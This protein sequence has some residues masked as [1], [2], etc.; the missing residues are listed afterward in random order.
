MHQGTSL[1]RGRSYCCF[2]LNWI[3]LERKNYKEIFFTQLI[4][5][6]GLD[7]IKCHHNDQI[8]RRKSYATVR[9]LLECGEK[10]VPLS[11]FKRL[12]ATKYMEVLD[13][14]SIRTMKHA[15]EVIISDMNA[16][17]SVKLI[18]IQF[19]QR[20]KMLRQLNTFQ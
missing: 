5:A 11:E 18:S 19:T 17:S 8:F 10:V 14:R 2:L 9:L 3:G 13:D 12:F 20:Y 7:Y 4:D 6:N 15:I 1:H 16:F